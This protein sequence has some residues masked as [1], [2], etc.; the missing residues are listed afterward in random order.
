ML[1]PPRILLATLALVDGLHRRVES[2]PEQAHQ[3]VD[4]RLGDDE[5]RQEAHHIVAGRDP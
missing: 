4:L 5:R 3:L 2:V 1:V